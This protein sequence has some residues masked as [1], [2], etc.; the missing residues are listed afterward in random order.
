MYKEP[1]FLE[2]ELKERIWGGERLRTE[3]GYQI[4][5][6]TTGECWGISAH[7]HG[8]STIK[9]GEL[10]GKTLIEAWDEHR[11]LFGHFSSEQFP[12]L[13]KILDAKTDLSVQVHPNDT[14]AREVENE[15]YG[16]TECWYII[17]CE[18]GSEIV[19]GHHAKSPEEFRS[20]VEEGQ[21]D[22]LLRRVKVK[23]GDFFYVPSGTIHAIG[24]GI[25]ILESQQSSDI[26]YRVYDYDRTDAEGNK[27]ELHIEPSIEVSQYPHQSPELT[28][29]VEQ[30]REAKV[31]ELVKA[32]YFTVH[33]WDVR[34]Q[35]TLKMDQPFLLVSVIKGEGTIQTEGQQN[36][37]KKGDHFIIPA[38]VKEIELLG[39]IECVVSHP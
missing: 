16:K 7:P 17:D 39:H 37:I 1:L 13:T 20:L 12:L 27:R 14:Y 4:P 19:Y 2:P 24:G 10:K 29:K 34:G 33:H 23:P 25:M 18:E 30:Y 32:E 5:S 22:Q 3:F 21:W 31:T 11:E 8:P 26:T 36:P 38:T 6:E 28:Y 15:P 9:N 35:Y